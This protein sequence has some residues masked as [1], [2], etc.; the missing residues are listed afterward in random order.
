MLHLGPL[1]ALAKEVFGYSLPFHLVFPQHLA[2]VPICHHKLGRFL[3]FWSVAI[4]TWV[5][6]W[7]LL[8]FYYNSRLPYA[9]PVGGY[10]QRGVALNWTGLCGE[11][12]RAGCTGFLGAR[13][14]CCATNGVVL[15]SYTI[16]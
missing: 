4:C 9:S 14:W 12:R 6:P 11:N 16:F 8:R 3:L 2:L 7:R 15:R 1:N 13:T 10:L 5:D